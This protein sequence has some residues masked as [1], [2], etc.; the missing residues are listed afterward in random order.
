MI[1]A[2]DAQLAV[3][4]VYS[5]T[6]VRKA[7]RKEIDE[8]PGMDELIQQGTDLL[9]A[10]VDKAPKYYASKQ[11]RVQLLADLSFT[12]LVKDILITVLPV[13]TPM[14]FT[15]VVGQVAVSL[16]FSNKADGIK[17]AAEILAVLQELD[18]YTIYKQEKYDS[19]QIVCNY[20]LPEHLVRLIEQVKFLPP[21]ICRPRQVRSNYDSGYLAKKES[22]IL[23]SDNFHEGDICLDSLNKF[24]QVPLTLD[25]ELLKRYSEP[26]VDFDSP[27]KRAKWQARNPGMS[28]EVE[29]KDRQEKWETMVRD[30]Y[31]VYVDLVKQGNQFWLTHGVDKR[32]RTYARGYHVNTQGNSFR[33]AIV[34]LYE[35]EVIQGVPD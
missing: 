31:K 19:L 6:N 21:M 27:E 3:E 18:A 11:R 12:E 29:L 20:E 8:T 4:R 23:G 14:L 16:G 10:Y 2:V 24:N 9:Q 34:D 30:S 1:N 33:K 35:K 15:N 26:P 7:I 5:K 28:W 32:G 22:L 25:V 13:Q 17:T